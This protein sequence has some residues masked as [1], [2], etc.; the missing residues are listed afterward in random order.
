MREPKEKIRKIVTVLFLAICKIELYSYFVLLSFFA[1]AVF[2]AWMD[3]NSQLAKKTRMCARA[4][5]NTHTHTTHVHKNIFGTILFIYFFIEIIF[6]VG[7]D[8]CCR[9]VYVYMYIFS[10]CLAFS[11]Y[12]ISSFF[13]CFCCQTVQM[14]L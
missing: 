5:I 6:F 9:T 14:A 8:A 1:M 10:V 3:K 7:M 12:F 11:F 2:D 13:V 4:K